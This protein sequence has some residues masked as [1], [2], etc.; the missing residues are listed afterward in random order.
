M[1]QESNNILTMGVLKMEFTPKT[2]FSWPGKC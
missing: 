2:C 1:N